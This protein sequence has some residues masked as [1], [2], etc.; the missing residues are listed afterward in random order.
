MDGL[1]PGLDLALVPIWG[2]GPTIGPGHLDPARA[3]RA[4][5]LLRPRLA[6]PIHW[7]TLRPVFHSAHAPFLSEPLDAF[8]EAAKQDAPAVEVHVLQPGGSLQVSR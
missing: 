6:V 2:W 1:A 3:A 8:V 4:L 7:G 5:A